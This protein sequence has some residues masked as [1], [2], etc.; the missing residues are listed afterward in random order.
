MKCELSTLSGLKKKLDIQLSVEQVTKAM[1]DSS[2]N[3]QKTTSL[4]GFRKGKVPLNHIRS[5]YQEE[6]KKDTIIN[7]VNEFYTKALQQEKIHPVGEPQINLKSDIAEGKNFQFSATLEVHPEIKIDKDFKVKLKKSSGVVED[8]EVDQALE[9][10]RASTATFTPVLEDRGVEWGDIVELNIE[11][12]KGTEFLPIRK[13]PML[14]M[15]KEKEG[16]SPELKGLKEGVLGM[17][18]GTKKS[19][20]VELSGKAV[21]WEITLEALKKKNLPAL[22]MEFFQKFQCKDMEE[23]KKTVRKSLEKEKSNKN[24]EVLRKSVLDQ[25]VEK[26]PMD[27][28]PEGMVENQKK[29]IMFSVVNNL[30]QAGM[31]EKQVEDYKKKYADDFDKE[32]R[33]TVH[34]SYLIY[35]LAGKLN[36]SATSKEVQALWQQRGSSKGPASR[37]EYQQMENFLIQEKTLEHLIN[38]ANEA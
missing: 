15:S 6:I 38:T 2:K 24:Y 21:E 8:K 5:L 10:L 17:K 23:L 18:P 37:D 12:P 26:H 27:L 25:L 20:T 32:A 30:K 19:I 7:L 13:N 9:N 35:S 1:E 3:K 36:I 33:L 22:T 28:L 29:A 34:S 16:L 14:E 31:Q 11:Q 4:S